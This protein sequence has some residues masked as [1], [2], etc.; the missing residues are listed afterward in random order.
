MGE[1]V[2]GVGNILL[3]KLATKA[4]NE[5]ISAWGLKDDAERLQESVKLVNALLLDA[6]DKQFKDQSITAW[7]QLLKR[8][9]YDANIILDEIECQANISKVMKMHGCVS[10][11]VR[12]FFSSS[13]P[14]VFRVKMAHKIKD[15]REK[16]DEIALN[17]N[18]FGLIQRSTNDMA[19]HKMLPWR[20]T[21]SSLPSRVTG[22]DEEKEHII[23]LLM[24]EPSQSQSK[25]VDVIP[26]VAMGG[27][28][29]T[30]L[31][32]LVFNDSR[33]ADHYDLIL[34]VHVSQDFDV[35]RIISKI[36][37]QVDDTKGR[38]GDDVILGRLRTLLHEKLYED[39]ALERLK[40][41]LREK[42]YEKKFLLVLDDMWN[43]NAKRWHDLRDLLL[44]TISERNKNDC[45]IIV[46]TRSEGVADIVKT[47][48]KISLQELPEEE[49]LQLFFKCAFQE[50]GKAN[51][52]PRLQ[53]IGKEIV[54]K[55][56]G[57]PLAIVTLGCILR[58]QDDENEWKRIRDSEIWEID[59]Q[60]GEILPA[61]RL[62]YSQLP[63][64]LK[65]CFSYCALFPKGHEYRP[66]ELIPIWMAQG[67]LQPTNENEDPVCLGEL[68]FRQL[69]S[70]SFFQSEDFEDE[71][72][73]PFKYEVG[74]VL[75]V[76][77]YKMHALI[78]DLAMSTMHGETTVM[79]SASTH[80]NE[81][82]RHI[83]FSTI[84]DQ[85]LSLSLKRNKV[86]SFGNWHTQGSITTTEPFVKWMF[87]EF[88]YLRVL[89]LQSLAFLFLPDCFDKMKHL[90]YLNL[91]ECSELKKLPNSI[92]KLYNLQTLILVGCNAL[93]ELPKNL[94]NLFNL[95]ILMITA[96]I[97]NLCFVDIR[98]FSYLQILTIFSC[99]NLEVMPC[100]L[101][102]LVSL[103]KLVI[104]DCE[105]LV[106]FEDEVENEGRGKQNEVA[107]EMNL[108]IFAIAGSPMLINLPNWLQRSA[109][110][111]QQICI[112]DT[113]LTALPE[114]LP[115]ATSLNSLYILDCEEL[116]SLPENMDHCGSLQKLGI[117]GC[118]NLRE[119][120][121]W[122]VGPE[123]SKIA[124]V[125][126]VYVSFC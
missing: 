61:L 96:Q 70:L 71:F 86:Q 59:H 90:R 42:L 76:G 17:G 122:D 116:L 91:S 38:G 88:K 22:R 7:L 6:E 12:Q 2:S 5:I 40:T 58:S 72:G 48:T 4:Y 115:N 11:K 120:Y 114:W 55:C 100:D 60:K 84:P 95:R 83:S 37:T 89:D 30:T 112:W 105:K 109:K 69:I 28:G 110:T 31:A 104:M 85:L 107:K 32:Q 3:E 94:R 111:L 43:E 101:S 8:A 14:L 49:C 87:K 56:K 99:Y 78:H 54:A 93:E 36:V 15:I 125:P 52:C 51:Q 46:T 79:S 65:Q 44:D 118:P 77:R 1:I 29:K 24:R 117:S 23:S 50:E 34:W 45:K 10:Q 119:R 25:S 47:V 126:N 57:L 64:P 18:K 121:K 68:Y 39:M 62:S 26:I 113:S 35:K 82:V 75:G 27:C 53:E 19:L 21:H 67:L 97:T 20:E 124:H 9:F 106:R 102:H 74:K 66:I 33:I 98:F 80:V 41:L 63:S 73:S 103:K 92:S 16:I 108:Q 123:W 13:N 81:K